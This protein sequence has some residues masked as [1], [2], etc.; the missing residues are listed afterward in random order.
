MST[1]KKLDFKWYVLRTISG[2]EKKI[3]DYILQEVAG[4]GAAEKVPQVVIPVEKRLQIRNGKKVVVES[5]MMPGYMLLEGK[6]D[7][8]LISIIRNVPNVIDF[9][10]KENPTPLRES[11]AKRMLGIVDEL[12]DSSAFVTVPFMVGE[13]VKVT[14]GPF[15]D[16]TGVIDE[17]NEDKKK[18]RVMV[19]IFGRKT[20]LDLNYNQVERIS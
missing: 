16:F 6:L 11:E 1:E 14:D 8:D 9:L 10:G 18:L 7:P 12:T 19:K 13:S 3:K 17:V 5:N 15:N 2:K 4:V 20:P